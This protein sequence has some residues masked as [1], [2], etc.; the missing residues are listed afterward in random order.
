M[1]TR[2]ALALIFIP[3]LAINLSDSQDEKSVKTL[4]E[5]GNSHEGI[6]SLLRQKD[7]KSPQRKVS[8]RMSPAPRPILPISKEVADKPTFHDYPLLRQKD[9]KARV[10]KRQ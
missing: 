1:K 2:L 10:D 3:F 4:Q 7:Q 8:R 5:N 6:R 9:E